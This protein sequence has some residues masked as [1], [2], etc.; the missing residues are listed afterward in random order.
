MRRKMRRKSRRLPD[1]E[2]HALVHLDNA[3]WHAVLPR[4][5]R[6]SLDECGGEFQLAD[7]ENDGMSRL[8][9][10]SSPQH[11]ICLLPLASHSI[12]QLMTDWPA[13]HLQGP[14]TITTVLYASS[15]GA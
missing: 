11:D 7:N 10:C 5:P 12:F 9:K 4:L 1:I 15:L 13:S 6:G 2:H 14:A 8:V 3:S